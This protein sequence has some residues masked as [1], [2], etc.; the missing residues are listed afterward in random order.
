MA[1][2]AKLPATL[3]SWVASAS[4]PVT[5]LQE[6][7]GRAQTATAAQTSKTVATV[8]EPSIR[9]QALAT[10]RSPTQLPTERKVEALA[11]IFA[12][13]FNET[14]KVEWGNSLERSTAIGAKTGRDTPTD[15]SPNQSAPGWSHHRKRPK[16]HWTW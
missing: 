13:F 16:N 7:D 14:M 3:A 10:D 4:S 15:A 12:I 6:T 8:K 5:L 2:S 11:E 9:Q 1:P